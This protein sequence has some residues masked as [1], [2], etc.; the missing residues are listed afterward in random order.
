MSVKI[1]DISLCPPT[2][3]LEEE[4]QIEKTKDEEEKE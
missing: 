2:V 3:P 4:D 1:D